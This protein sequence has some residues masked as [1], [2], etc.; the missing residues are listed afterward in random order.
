MKTAILLGA[1]SSVPAGFPSTELLTEQ[2]LSSSGVC[3]HTDETYF[4]DDNL[5]TAEVSTYVTR[6]LRHIHGQADQYLMENANRPANYEDIYNII[7]QVYEER[8][9]ESENP[10]IYD[11]M[12][13]LFKYM[14]PLCGSTG[15]GHNQ[16]L[17]EMRN[18]IADVVW[19]FLSRTEYSSDHLKI[20]EA[21]CKS[22]FVSSISTLCHDTHV[23]TYLETQGIPLDDG[24]PEEELGARY[25][26]GDFS[27]AHKIPFLNLHGSVNWFRLRLDSSESFYDDRI[28]IPLD[29]DHDHVKGRDGEFQ[30][31]LD[32][33][34]ILLIGTFNKIPDYTRGIFRELHHQF[35]QALLASTQLL[36]CGCSFGDKGI[37]TAIIEWYYAERGRRFLT[38]HPDFEALI[39][40]ARGAIRNKWDEWVKCGGVRLIC[41]NIEDVEERELFGYLKK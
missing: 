13:K 26:H 20:L 17:N 30:F 24:F 29:G 22:N 14:E 35:R 32:G 16:L 4:I 15:M 11:Y 41:K 27:S 40:N 39:K 21:A 10:T 18:Y 28:G 36:I 34:P 25:W 6:L 23:E 12:D 8:F 37:N 31:S 38:I 3:R 19:R 9:G 33:R 5:P 1:G 7:D 2:V